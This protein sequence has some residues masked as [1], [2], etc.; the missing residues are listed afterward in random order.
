MS[1]ES[2]PVA[3]AAQGTLW[4]YVQNWAARGIT[5]VVFFTLARLLSP[6]EFGAFAVTMVF[7]TLGEMFVEQLFAPALIQREQLGADHLDSA[8]WATVGS[9]VLC[10]AGTLLAAPLFARAFDAPGV[11]PLIMALSPVFGLMALAAI[12]GALLR[13]SLNYRTLARRTA[14]SNLI[15]GTVAIGAAVAGLG[16]WAFILQQ[17]V[18]QVV[19]TFI[20]WRNEPW[21]PR[22]RFHLGALREL[23]GFSASMTFIKVLEIGET[24]VVELVVGRFMGLASLGNYALAARAHQAA[25]QLLAA[26]LWESSVGAFARQQS[27]PRSITQSLQQRA[28]LASV[29][30]APAFLFAAASGELLIPA[31]FGAKWVGAVTA[32]QVLCLLGAVRAVC[33]LYGA[34]LQAIGEAKASVH[35]A[36]VRAV[37][38]LC[39]L[40]VLLN[41]GPAG[42]AACLLFGQI[43]ALP[44]IF[45]VIKQRLGLSSMQLF[46][47]VAKPITAS[48]LASAAGWAVANALLGRMPAVFGAALSLATCVAVFLLLLTVLMPRVLQAAAT[49]LPARFGAGRLAHAFDRVAR[50]HDQW[51]STLCLAAMSS[52]VRAASKSDRS[53]DLVVVLSDADSVDGS[54]GNQALFYGLVTTLKAAGVRRVRLLCRKSMVLPDTGADL[55]FESLPHWGSLRQARSLARQI[56]DARALVVV[57]ADVLDGVHS[58]FES[59]LRLGLAAW[60]ARRAVPSLL[61]SFSLAERLDPAASAAFGRLPA[62][63]VLMCSD[64]LTHERVAAMV[65]ARVELAA[66]L[67]FAMPPA[68]RSE[69]G[70][71]VAAW[72]AASHRGP[73]PV[74]GWNLSSHGWRGLTAAQRQQAIGTAAS[75]MARLIAERGASV[76]L[77]PGDFRSRADE[78]ATLA[79]VMLQLPE[80]LS[81]ERV[82]RPDVAFSAA[83]FKGCCQAH[84][85][86]MVTSCPHVTIAALGAGV[87]VLTANAGA[88]AGPGVFQHFGLW[89]DRPGPADRRVEADRLHGRICACIDT[90]SAT[91]SQIAS[92]RHD[93]EVL[94]AS[95]LNI[96]LRQ[97]GPSLT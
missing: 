89:P 55:V 85:D 17:L 7:L 20:L 84:F 49:R 63:V 30:I 71:V 10:T 29:L 46:V 69:L 97:Q 23:S 47:N 79:E 81:S 26:P 16:V 13:R 38:T 42:V 75:T 76:V 90:L 21:R 57:G 50:F 54:V 52:A 41:H 2:R 92:R 51:R 66:D 19:G 59:L 14:A 12:P 33:F 83:E 93:V 77:L 43:A 24:R 27:D 78:A 88:G 94:A 34:L 11:E 3:S 39:C 60:C 74:I 67:G 25:T 53:G 61:C 56:A 80:G 48:L 1:V 73:G 32:F 4:A 22:W 82:L 40:P 87:P 95:A 91:R 18:F 64:A 44:I 5:L 31:V 62:E 45:R 15:S 68:G 72:L 36:V 28:I 96:C 35:V 58:R 9:A 6:A 8:F 37:V 86:L 65:A 70:D